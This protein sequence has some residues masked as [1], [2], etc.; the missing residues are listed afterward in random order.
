MSQ[1]RESC[2]GHEVRRQ[3]QAGGGDVLAVCASSQLRNVPSRL[4]VRITHRLHR[5][6]SPCSSRESARCC[7]ACLVPSPEPRLL[8]P[9]LLPFEPGGP[10][11]AGL[12]LDGQ[13]RFQ[14]HGHAAQALRVVAA[15][16]LG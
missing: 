12:P 11:H 4:H 8:R 5:L 3:L 9:A 2:A 15:A 13:M 7:I 6:S 1:V 16:L 10:D 14:L